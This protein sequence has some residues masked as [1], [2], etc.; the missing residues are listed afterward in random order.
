MD[1]YALLR[2]VG[3]NL[4]DTQIKVLKNFFKKII[5]ESGS[6]GSGGSGGAS[7]LSE[8]SD[9]NIDNPVDGQTLRFSASANKWKS[10]GGYTEINDDNIDDIVK[11]TSYLTIEYLSST[12]HSVLQ[13]RGPFPNHSDFAE[14]PS[15]KVLP[16]ENYDCNTDSF[17][18]Y[19]HLNTG[20]KLATTEEFI[21]K[22]LVYKNKETI[23][24]YRE[25]SEEFE[26]PA[27]V[28][29]YRIYDNFIA[30]DKENN[31]YAAE[32]FIPIF[33]VY[34]NAKGHDIFDDTI[35]FLNDIDI[36]NGLIRKPNYHMSYSPIYD[37]AELIEKKYVIIKTD[38]NLVSLTNKYINCFVDIFNKTTVKSS[39]ST[40]NVNGGFNV[41]LKFY[42]CKDNI[43][44][45]TYGDPKDYDWKPGG[46]VQPA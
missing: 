38:L 1:I 15:V 8:L 39:V 35:K 21:R 41:N 11:N 4:N 19:V 37:S 10:V 36:T 32:E 28:S 43:Y 40:T 46:D 25:H 29:D 9:V 23:D 7:A 20:E 33:G 5:D 13:Y 6:G 26:I 27:S 42:H 22:L 16:V 17:G 34:F 2:R 18:L 24:F 12:P 31:V 14:P 30:M 44:C 3:Y 45:S